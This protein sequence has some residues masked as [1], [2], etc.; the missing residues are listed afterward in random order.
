MDAI[1]GENGIVLD[2]GGGHGL[3]A[4]AL[5]EIGFEKVRV[6]DSDPLAIKSCENRGIDAVCG[7]VLSAD[8]H[9]QGQYI[10]FNLI[11]HHLVERSEQD[12]MSFQKAAL[13]K[14]RGRFRY[15]FVNEYICESPIIDGLSA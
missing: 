4:S 11:L 3:F 10:C 5:R 9:E 2:V 15:I 13:G 1:A 8:L 6:V 7:D 14:W 12:N